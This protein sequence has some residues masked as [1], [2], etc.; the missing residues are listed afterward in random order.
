MEVCTDS[1]VYQFASKPT[2]FPSS[3][4][5]AVECDLLSSLRVSLGSVSI[6]CAPVRWYALVTTNALSEQ[7]ACEAFHTHH[8]LFVPLPI[9][10]SSSRPSIFCNHSQ[11]ELHRP[12]AVPDLSPQSSQL[13]KSPTQRQP[14]HTRSTTDRSSGNIKTSRLVT[15]TVNSSAV[16]TIEYKC[17]GRPRRLRHRRA[18]RGY[19]SRTPDARRLPSAA[20]LPTLEGQ[21][22]RFTQA[23]DRTVPPTR[24]ERRRPCLRRFWQD[25][26]HLHQF[27]RVLPAIDGSSLMAPTPECGRSALRIH[28]GLHCAECLRYQSYARPDLQPAHPVP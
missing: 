4:C 20:S 9:S 1:C 18:A 17:D 14:P 13:A 25:A 10:S 12:S 15:P 5:A 3:P 27:T 24:A 22:C 7:S 8:C 28:P 21:H 19:P 2:I 6:G 16:L 26:R 11:F 23:S